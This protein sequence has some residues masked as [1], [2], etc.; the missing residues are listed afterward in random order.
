VSPTTA[1]VC[2]LIVASLG[3]WAPIAEASE[4]RFFSMNTPE[5]FLEGELDGVSVDSLGTLELA[6]RVAR[7]GEVEEPFVFAAARHPDGW[8]LG[9]GNAGRVVLVDRQGQPTIL[10]EVADPTIFAVTVDSAGVVYAGSSPGGVVYRIADGVSDVFYETGETY[11]WSLALDEQGVLWV[12]TGTE[13]RL[14]RVGRNGSGEVALDADDV[15][16]RSLTIVPGDGLLLGTGG[17]GLILRLSSDGSARTLYDSDLAEVVDIERGANGICFAAVVE[18]KAGLMDF[19]RPPGT[20]E[21]AGGVS[22]TVVEQEAS[23]SGRSNGAPGPRSRILRFPCVGG[24]M[25]TVWSFQEETAYDL[26]WFGGR[27]WIGTGE[28]GKL[29][30]LRDGSVVL[31]KDVDE[32]QIVAVMPDQHGPALATTNAAALRVTCGSRF[33]VE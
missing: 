12:A 28:E 8:V 10:M 23:V 17:E 1:G 6:H 18:A 9:T 11:I 2:R 19:G 21:P 14:H 27:L 3:L 13:G 33:A 30:S 29:Y 16:L 24:V 4:V 22:V 7:V 5:A 32:R 25:E 20:G 15:H 31:E 26:L